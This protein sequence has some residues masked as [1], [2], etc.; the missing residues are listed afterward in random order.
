MPTHV[1]IAD[2]HRSKHGQR[3]YRKGRGHGETLEMRQSDY[4]IYVDALNSAKGLVVAY[5][6]VPGRTLLEAT[7]EQMEEGELYPDQLSDVISRADEDKQRRAQREEHYLGLRPDMTIQRKVKRFTG[8]VPKKHEDVRGKYVLLANAW[9]MLYL[10][11]PSRALLRDFTPEI[12]SVALDFLFGEKV[13][14]KTVKVGFGSVA[15][16]SWEFFLEFEFAFR[17]RLFMAIDSER[18]LLV[19]AMKTAIHDTG[20]YQDEFLTGLRVLSMWLPSTASS[21]SA[22]PRPTPAGPS[23][24]LSEIAELAKIVED[25]SKSVA[26]LAKRKDSSNGG[27]DK[28]KGNKNGNEDSARQQQQHKE[29]FNVYMREPRLRQQPHLAPDG[30]KICFKFQKNLCSDHTCP[31]CAQV[32]GLSGYLYRFRPMRACSLCLRRVNKTNACEDSRVYSAILALAR[33]WRLPV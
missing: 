14:G 1:D 6:R 25:L 16:P 7:I 28:C 31:F 18:Q 22:S 12:F 20:L 29:K 5:E 17:K 27:G 23:G 19:T 2:G 33:R 10:R 32:R 8:T 30:G 4:L 15:P 21:S 11:N 13:L 3:I 26:G 9:Q 24:P